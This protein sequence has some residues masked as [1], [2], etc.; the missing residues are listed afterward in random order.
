MVCTPSTRPLLF[1]VK[2]KRYYVGL[3]INHRMLMV[4]LM[5]LSTGQSSSTVAPS[6]LAPLTKELVSPVGSTQPSDFEY[7]P[8]MI[9]HPAREILEV[10]HKEE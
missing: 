9:P 6:V 3:H 7:S 10:P 8:P 4:N 2:T 5:I 1:L